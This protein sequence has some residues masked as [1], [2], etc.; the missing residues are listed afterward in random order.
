MEMAT[1]EDRIW[2][3]N[4][5]PGTE[6]RGSGGHKNPGH[7]GQWEAIRICDTHMLRWA[8]AAS[9]KT[10]GRGIKGWPGSG[11]GRLGV[12][13]R[14]FT[15][16]LFVPFEFEPCDSITYSKKKIKTIRNFQKEKFSLRGFQMLN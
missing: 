13:G 1:R 8:E 2:G 10:H 9:V 15:V 14:C 7:Q 5:L 11:T 3:T 12:E 16:D 4:F 6:A